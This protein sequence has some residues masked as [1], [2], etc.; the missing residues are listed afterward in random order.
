MF[1]M[2]LAHPD[3]KCEFWAG[4]TGKKKKKSMHQ[5]RLSLNLENKSFL[6]SHLIG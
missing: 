4:K 1:I 5:E 6:L 2:T 3:T